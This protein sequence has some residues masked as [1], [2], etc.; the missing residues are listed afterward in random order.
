MSGTCLRALAARSVIVGAARRADAGPR[1]PPTGRPPP[2]KSLQIHS[3]SRRACRLRLDPGRGEDGA[4][5]Q[6][7]TPHMQRPSSGGPSRP[8]WP[9]PNMRRTQSLAHA[10]AAGDRAGWGAAHT[11][12]VD[13][14]ARP[15]IPARAQG[16]GTFDNPL[17][18]AGQRHFHNPPRANRSLLRS[19]PRCA[20]S[21]AQPP[22]GRPC[23]RP[24]PVASICWR[25]VRVSCPAPRPARGCCRGL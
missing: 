14:A 16:T 24:P 19:P 18:R 8:A 2:H 15:Y 6:L 4:V 10:Q 11:P 12:G 3:S 5:D 21:L 23:P 17:A 13:G 20:T 1:L 25:P 22:P 7:G 9:M